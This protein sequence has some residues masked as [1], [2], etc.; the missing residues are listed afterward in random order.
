M[1]FKNLTIIGTSHIAK[2]SMQEI[3]DAVSKEKPDIIAIELDKKRFIALMH[4]KKG[5]E[6]RI[7]LRDIRRIGIKGYLFS[8]IGGYIQKKL[9][10]IVGVAPGSE[11]KKAVRLAK[12]NKLQIAL[13]D[14]DIE[15]T[16]KRF[17]KSFTWKE[18]WHIIEDIVKGLLFR[19]NAVKFDLAKVPDKEIVKK[20]MKQVK[21]RYPNLY[22]VLV[23]ERNRI[24]ANN[25]F[26]IMKSHPN[27]KILAVVGA[28]H[29]EDMMKIIEAKYKLF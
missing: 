5:K 11:M 18:K 6:D 24:M 23:T 28:G 4:K 3:E 16:L 29:A 27:K 13:I 12:K 2:Q 10:K 20:L 8:L 9:G 14:Q 26:N 19:K 21:E 15:L 17:S 7:R 22:K 25:L 1:H